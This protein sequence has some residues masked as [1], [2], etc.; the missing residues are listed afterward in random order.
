MDV[1]SDSESLVESDDTRFL[2]DLRPQRNGGYRMS[3]KIVAR[4][5]DNSTAIVCLSDVVTIPEFR[6][7]NDA[8]DFLYDAVSGYPVM[9]EALWLQKFDL[10]SIDVVPLE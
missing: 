2:I 10:A 9:C 8:V 3:I 7:L 5:L 6:S 1:L 4:G